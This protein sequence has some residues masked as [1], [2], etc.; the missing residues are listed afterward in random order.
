MRRARPADGSVGRPPVG[1]RP[2]GAGSA[3]DRPGG[4]GSATDRP[5]ADGSQAGDAGESLYLYG[6]VSAQAQSPSPEVTGVG[7]RGV[8][9]LPLDGH[10]AVVS[11]VPAEEY[12]PGAVEDRMEDL[13][14]VAEQGLGHERVV[15]WF[16][17]HAWI[18]PARLLTLYSSAEALRQEAAE[19]GETIGA[20]FEEMEGLYEWDLK[21]GYEAS[22]LR[23]NLGEVSE[24]M[25]EL[26][27]EMMSATPGRQYL[28]GRKHR[29]RVKDETRRAARRL[30]HELYE[31]VEGQVEE[32]RVL[33]QPRRR[34]AADLPVVLNAAFLVPADRQ[35]RIRE[36]VEARAEQ[37]DRWGV[38]VSFSGPWAPYRFVGDG[39]GDG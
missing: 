28:L 17:D 13:E 24:E 1:G 21:V 25:A 6:F 32:A 18:L 26:E 22:R 9:L 5:R 20:T 10:F 8:E 38:N 39:D 34:E 15:T 7:D 23:E 30:A 29:D 19:R 14:W 36:E 12:A 3:T 16:V 31:E 35:E 37:L 4:A 27:E 2:G 11:R 33:D